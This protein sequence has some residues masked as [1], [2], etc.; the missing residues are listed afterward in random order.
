MGK[1]EL[2]K[3]TLAELKQMAK[4]M[5][6]GAV[7]TLKKGELIER[8]LQKQVQPQPSVVKRV[9]AYGFSLKE[10]GEATEEQTVQETKKT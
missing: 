3:K 7:S 6:L 2:Q 5:G 10:D 8:I 9:T 1:D 4:D